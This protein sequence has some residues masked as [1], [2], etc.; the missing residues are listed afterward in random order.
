MVRRRW[1]LLSR[2]FGIFGMT[3]LCYVLTD[4]DDS[5]RCIVVLLTGYDMSEMLFGVVDLA[6]AMVSSASTGP[7][8]ALLPR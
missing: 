3:C 1:A 4:L 5:R 8:S 2:M 6:A 7:Q